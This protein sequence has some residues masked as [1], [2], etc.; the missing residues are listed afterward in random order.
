MNFVRKPPHASLTRVSRPARMAA[1]LDAAK[2]FFCTVCIGFP[3]ETLRRYSLNMPPSAF[4]INAMTR[5]LRY[6]IGV[7]RAHDKS[8]LADTNYLCTLSAAA[9]AESCILASAVAGIKSVC[10]LMVSRCYGNRTG[11][12]SLH[13]GFKFLRFP[14]SI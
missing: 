14:C 6:R 10:F 4:F 9:A 8:R 11:L 13:S 12:S 3:H 1:Y 7:L 5:C 2:N